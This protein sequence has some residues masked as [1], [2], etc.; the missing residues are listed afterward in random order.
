VTE[1]VTARFEVH[2]RRR[3]NFDAVRRPDDGRPT[4]AINQDCL[5]PQRAGHGG[6]PSGAV[7]RATKVHHAAI[8]GKA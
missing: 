5:K 2:G 7:P 6:Q 1:M 8:V 3:W 4:G